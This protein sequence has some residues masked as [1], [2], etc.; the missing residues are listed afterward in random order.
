MTATYVYIISSADD[1]LYVDHTADLFRRLREH[2]RE[3][4]AHRIVNVKA[5][6]FSSAD[7]AR[8]WER[9]Y[10]ADLEPEFNT[11]GNPRHMTWDRYLDWI[12]A[13]A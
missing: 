12:G 9:D 2:G 13:V 6:V 1:T 5:Y 3:L 8:G 11:Q 4:W 10:I 7:E